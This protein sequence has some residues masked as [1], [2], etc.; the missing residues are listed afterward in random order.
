MDWLC[1][2]ISP[3]YC[4]KGRDSVLAEMRRIFGGDLEDIRFVEEGEEW[5]SEGG[6]C[7]LKCQ[8]YEDY[9]PQLRLSTAVVGVLPSYESPQYLTDEEIASFYG[10]VIEDG[11]T[12]RLFRGDIVVVTGGYLTGLVGIVNGITRPNVYRVVFRFHIRCFEERL[13]VDRLLFVD[14]LF[15]HMKKP[16][17]GVEPGETGR[18]PVTRL[19]E[20]ELELCAKTRANLSEI[21][22]GP[23]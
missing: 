22:W 15:R 12:S 21:H 9:V 8:D 11:R 23:D 18:F 4:R 10:H 16:V 6:Y 5:A 1:L 20:D 19:S 3:T 7:F 13:S 17:L 2:I 14:N